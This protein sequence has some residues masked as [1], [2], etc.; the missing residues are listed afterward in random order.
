MSRNFQR[1]SQ[2]LLNSTEEARSKKIAAD[3]FYPQKNKQEG[4][5]EVDI[6]QQ[7]EHRLFLAV[8]QRVEMHFGHAKTGE[9]ENGTFKRKSLLTELWNLSIFGLTN[10]TT[11]DSD[12]KEKHNLRSR[13]SAG[14]TLF[15]H[16]LGR[17][18]VKLLISSVEAAFQGSFRQD[19]GNHCQQKIDQAGDNAGRAFTN[20]LVTSEVLNRKRR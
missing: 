1:Y 8:L 11:A 15:I 16:E 6:Q 4:E 19:D 12:A 9:G 7:L 3:G 5:G 10:D 18:F 14:Y 17:A 20:R 2:W 13:S